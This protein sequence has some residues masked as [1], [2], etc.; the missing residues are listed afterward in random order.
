[1]CVVYGNSILQEHGD[2]AAAEACYCYTKD[3][4]HVVIYSMH[5]DCTTYMVLLKFVRACMQYNALITN[6]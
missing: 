2:A 4:L 3:G 5:T 6:V 1:M